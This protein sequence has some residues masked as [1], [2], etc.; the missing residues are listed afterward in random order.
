[1]TVLFVHGDL[2]ILK[3]IDLKFYR[4]LFHC[5]LLFFRFRVGDNIFYSDIYKIKLIY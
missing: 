5:S 2:D 3:S 1:M 4:R